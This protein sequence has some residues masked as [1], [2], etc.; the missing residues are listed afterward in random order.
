[1]TKTFKCHFYGAV[2]TQVREKKQHKIQMGK[3]PHGK[4]KYRGEKE[5]QREQNNN[6]HTK[7][8]IEQHII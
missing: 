4:E 8:H 5:K 6:S 1:M 7:T 3:K 2:K